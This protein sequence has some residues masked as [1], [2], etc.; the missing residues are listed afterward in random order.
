MR[1]VEWVGKYPDDIICGIYKKDIPKNHIL[2]SYIHIKFRF[3]TVWCKLDI[4]GKLMCKSG[5]LI[6][7]RAYLSNIGK[8]VIGIPDL[9]AADNT[10][11]ASEW[12]GM[13]AGRI[14]Q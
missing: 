3:Q 12:R 10:K 14:S 8:Y 11:F 2:E 1:T 6:I 5:E 4:N 7:V 9:T 13:L